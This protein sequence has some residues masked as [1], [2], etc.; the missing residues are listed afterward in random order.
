MCECRNEVRENMS[1]N[2]I[3]NERIST[4]LTTHDFYYDLPEELIAQ[5]PSDERD[6]C[7][8]MVLDRNTGTL[9]HRI[10]RDIVDQCRFQSIKANHK[11]A[12]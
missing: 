12:V 2:R 9:Q 6:G 1:Q 8:L 4:D 11:I 5:S 7:R 10:F 3:V